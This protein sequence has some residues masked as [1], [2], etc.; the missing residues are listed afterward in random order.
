MQCVAGGSSG[1]V[2]LT[3]SSPFPGG[4]FLAEVATLAKG[5]VQ[6]S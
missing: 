4:L 3:F 1:E 6:T 5:Y 2:R